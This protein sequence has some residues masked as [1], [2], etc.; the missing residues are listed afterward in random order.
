LR[1][2][3]RYAHLFDSV[4]RRA[5]RRRFGSQDAECLVPVT[6]FPA[7][8][9]RA[10]AAGI[11][12]RDSWMSQLFGLSRLEVRITG[13][14]PQLPGSLT[15]PSLRVPTGWVAGRPTC[16]GEPFD[17]LA[18]GWVLSCTRFTG[19]DCITV[20]VLDGRFAMGRC[21]WLGAVI[22]GLILAVTPVMVSA[23]PAGAQSTSTGSVTA[24]GDATSY[25]SPPASQLNAPVA[26]MAS[27]PDRK[28]YWLVGAD[29]GVFT[30]GDAGFYG[31]ETGSGVF[32]PFVGIA[33]TPD[34]HGYWV[35]DDFGNVYPFG[36]ATQ[37]GGAAGNMNAPS[38]ASPPRR[39]AWATGWSAR[40]VACSAS[41]TPAF[42]ARWA[43][44]RRAAA[45]RSSRSRR[46]PMA[47]ATGSRP[48]TK[49][50]PRPRLCPRYWPSA[51]TR[52]LGR[53]SSPAPSC[54]PV[55]TATPSSP[56]SPGLHGLRRAPPATATSPTTPASPTVQGARLF[57]ARRAYGSPTR[58]ERAPGRSSQA[59]A[60][61]TPTRP[62]PAD[63]QPSPE[64]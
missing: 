18:T 11:L 35:A 61:P 7:D 20:G 19:G 9:G 52:G 44:L 63:T 55:G 40:M 16:P 4:G 26:G 47:A 8:I 36:D 38:S 30:Y 33:P 60:T 17:Q 53:R 46:P 2:P 12:R 39:R 1:I 42:T 15:Y 56:I 54:A 10:T 24:F 59:P 22:V 51:T 57:P 14:R 58:S 50:C 62:P 43:L 29:G 32:T 41:A 27:T 31:S 45:L 37:L 64:R 3:H 5:S 25:G 48:R 28:G 49:N 21:W 34:G 13:R 6:E 23:A